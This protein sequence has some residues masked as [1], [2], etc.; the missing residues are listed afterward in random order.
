MML[1]VISDYL[2]LLVHFIKDNLRRAIPYFHDDLVQ[3]CLTVPAMW[4]EAA[5]SSM[6]QAAQAAGPLATSH[7][8]F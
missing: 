3:W 8:L 7:S 6:R 1:Q 5:K 4:S 2:Q